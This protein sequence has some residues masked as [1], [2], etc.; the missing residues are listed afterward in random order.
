MESREHVEMLD[1]LYASELGCRPED[2]YSGKTTLVSLERVG[3]I[4][5]A[6]GIPLVVFSIAKTTGAV[7][8][9]LPQL[10]DAADRAIEGRTT[11]DDAWDAVESAVTP[12]VDAKCW[13]RGCRFYC[14]SE[15]FADQ[16]FGEVR[17]MTDTDEI[18]AGLH[19]KWGGRVFGQIVDGRAVTWAAVKPLSDVVWDLSIQTLPEHRGRGYAKSAV[20]AAMKHI[21]E[22]GK[23]AAWGADR[24]NLASLRT[25]RSVG[26]EEY[27]LDFGCV[28]H[29]SDQEALD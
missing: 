23:L 9:V 14:S 6:K 27:G 18:A 29:G 26:F 7:V 11:L 19:A 2:F 24:T 5:F 15:T 17:D 20:S 4:R 10:K 28:V 16:E 3:G 8:S 25:A 21:F 12:L 22:N 13:F 1:R